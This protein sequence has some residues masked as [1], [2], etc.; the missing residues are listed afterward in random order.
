M[1]ERPIVRPHPRTGALVVVGAR[2]Q[3][4]YTLHPLVHGNNQQPEDLLLDELEPMESTSS[5]VCSK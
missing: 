2:K 3:P 5:G 4:D 1:I